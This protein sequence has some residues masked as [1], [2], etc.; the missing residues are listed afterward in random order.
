[1]A[2]KGKPAKKSSRAFRSTGR[3]NIVS[4]LEGRIFSLTLAFVLSSD[5][6]TDAFLN[7]LAQSDQHL[8]LDYITQRHPMETGAD[9]LRKDNRALGGKKVKAAVKKTTAKS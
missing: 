5:S 2:E 1:M 8:F 7:S 3:F 9:A 6:R 4:G